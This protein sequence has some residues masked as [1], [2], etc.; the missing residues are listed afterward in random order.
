M[1]RQSPGAARSQGAAGAV[2]LV[3]NHASGTGLTD[4]VGVITQVLKEPK[5][6]L[7]KISLT[8]VYIE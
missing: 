8:E 2:G 7:H 5:A 1:T 6:A 3:R 4:M